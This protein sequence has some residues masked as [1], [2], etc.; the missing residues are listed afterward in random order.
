M[1]QNMKTFPFNVPRWCPIVSAAAF[2]LMCGVGSAKPV[3]AQ[4]P[5]PAVPYTVIF[6]GL[7]TKALEDQV[8]AASQLVRLEASPPAS[9]LGLRRRLRADTQRVTE[10][11]RSEGYYGARVVPA[12]V[13]PEES[14]GSSKRTDV[15]LTILPGPQ[16]VF[17]SPSVSLDPALE[18]LPPAVG[19]SVNELNGA[20]ARAA[21]VITAE[22]AAVAALAGVGYPFARALPRR[23]EVDRPSGH[24]V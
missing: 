18:E 17:V 16:Y 20:P 14:S 10:V 13:R 15:T 3:Q 4:E 19:A 6:T 9:V 11:L 12:L 7:P 1:Q 22:Q 5:S 24:G 21:A 23:A 8:K 2:A